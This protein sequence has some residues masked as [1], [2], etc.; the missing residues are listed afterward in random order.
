MFSIRTPSVLKCLPRKM[1]AADMVV[2][3]RASVGRGRGF[4][5][6]PGWVSAKCM[7]DRHG[8]KCSSL[9]CECLCHN[10]EAVRQR[11]LMTEDE[12]NS[13]SAHKRGKMVAALIEA[14]RQRSKEI[15]R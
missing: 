13:L 9:T 6:D 3:K 1:R 7:N 8:Y 4:A 10:Q 2:Y 14:D 5:H 15:G 12:W 11:L